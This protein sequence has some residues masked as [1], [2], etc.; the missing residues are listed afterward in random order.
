[1]KP[2]KFYLPKEDEFCVGTRTITIVTEVEGGTRE[3]GFFHYTQDGRLYE[4]SYAIVVKAFRV[5]EFI[6]GLHDLGWRFLSEFPGT[7][8]EQPYLYSR[9]TADNIVETL[10]AFHELDYPNT[11]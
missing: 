10:S 6:L 11:Y 4:V 5:D 3:N 1:M 2:T 7:S 9:E 8:W